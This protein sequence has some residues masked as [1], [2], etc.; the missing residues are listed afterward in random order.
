V[1]ILN[2]LADEPGR[3]ESRSDVARATGVSSATSLRI[4]ES[5]RR[6][7]YVS[8]DP[9]GKGYRLGPALIRLGAAARQARAS[10]EAARPLMAAFTQRLQMPMLAWALVDDWLVILDGVSAAPADSVTSQVGLRVP[11]APP[12]GVLHVAWGHDDDVE[13]WLAR[14]PLYPLDNDL[15]RLR[16]VIASCRDDGYAVDR[17]DERTRMRDRLLVSHSHPSLPRSIREVLGDVLSTIGESY[18]VS[19]ELGSN[20]GIPVNGISSPSFDPDGK[21]GLILSLCVRR[22]HVAS[23]Q[24]KRWGRAMMELAADVTATIGGVNPR[25]SKT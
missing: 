5:L 4:L 22:H 12:A 21:P 25:R 3:C 10:V 2:Q 17:L 9:L 16:A 11:F 24:I 13:T 23:Q 8:R 18:Y 15:S 6:A 19:A 1:A 14:R 7:G 20:N